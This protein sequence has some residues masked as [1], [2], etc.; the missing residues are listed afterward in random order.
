MVSRLRES[1]EG[2]GSKFGWTTRQFVQVAH[3]ETART[4]E[5]KSRRLRLTSQMALR[6]MVSGCRWCALMRAARWCSDAS[7]RQII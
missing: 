3:V 4:R 2:S 5:V 6:K 7:V 1:S